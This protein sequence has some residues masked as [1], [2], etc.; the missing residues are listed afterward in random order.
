MGMFP[1]THYCAKSSRW[2]SLP[3]LTAKRLESDGTSPSLSTTQSFRILDCYYSSEA[4]A[5]A[6][7]KLGEPTA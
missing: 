1:G 6:L 3:L 4:K 2:G 5:C 7:E